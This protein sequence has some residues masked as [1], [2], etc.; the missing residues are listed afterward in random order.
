MDWNIE[1]K[2]QAVYSMRLDTWAGLCTHGQGYVHMG[3]AMPVVLKVKVLVLSCI[4]LFATPWTIACQAPL[5]LEFSK[6]EYWSG[7]PFPSPGD[8]PDPGIKPG[9]PVLQRDC[10][11][12]NLP[13]KPQ[14]VLWRLNFNLRAMED[15]GGRGQAWSD[16]CLS[17]HSTV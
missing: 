7:L 10:L 9:S 8:L 16:P 5:S 15:H 12:S 4:Q 1:S 2:G 14:V 11:P 6:Q 13:G 3:R 17:P